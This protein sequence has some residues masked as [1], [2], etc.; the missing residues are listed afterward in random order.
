MAIDLATPALAS[1]RTPP[2]SSR[3]QTVKL[4][5]GSTSCVLTP[6]PETGLCREHRA[7]TIASV[8]ER[9]A[10]GAAQ[11]QAKSGWARGYVAAKPEPPKV[12]AKPVITEDL[13]PD[14]LPVEAKPLSRWACQRCTHNQGKHRKT[15]CNAI[16]CECAGA[17]K[18]CTGCDG[19]HGWGRS[20]DL[21]RACEGKQQVA[22][23]DKPDEMTGVCETREQATAMAALLTEPSATEPQVVVVELAGPTDAVQRPPEPQPALKPS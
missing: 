23:V 3:K 7:Q 18:R 6:D 16:G 2:S 14:R 10:E 19:W 9:L 22:A 4:C 12:E 17:V 1:T 15:G 8:Q 20:S 11:A 21:C 13:G 5:T